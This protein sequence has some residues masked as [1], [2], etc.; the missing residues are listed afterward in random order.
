MFAIVQTA[1]YVCSKYVISKCSHSCCD[2]LLYLESVRQQDFSC[3]DV[4]KLKTRD[5]P[6]RDFA[7]YP[8]F[9]RTGYSVIPSKIM[10]F[11]RNMANMANMA[12]LSI[13]N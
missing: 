9:I 8:V 1:E 11:K 10:L 3:Y 6:D 7:G 2:P 5:A 13:I 4:L 12:V